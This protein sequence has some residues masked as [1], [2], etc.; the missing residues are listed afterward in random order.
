MPRGGFTRGKPVSLSD[1][2]RKGCVGGVCSGASKNERHSD[3]GHH[4]CEAPT[5]CQVSA[6]RRH[7]VAVA[8]VYGTVSVARRGASGQ[9]C[10][11][12]GGAPRLHAMTA[13]LCRPSSTCRVR[14]VVVVRMALA[15]LALSGVCQ[16][17]RSMYHALSRVT[18]G[19]GAAS[20]LAVAGRIAGT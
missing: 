14:S 7:P 18:S 4:H 1:H 10:A 17:Y 12:K 16:R 11:G 20:P 8:C 6:V 3:D 2:W 19:G 13:S 5:G 9:A 15:A